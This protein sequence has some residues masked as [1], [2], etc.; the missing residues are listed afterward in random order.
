[1]FSPFGK[2]KQQA[3]PKRKAHNEMKRKLVYFIFGCAV[4]AVAPYVS[5]SVARLVSPL[6]G[7]G[8]YI[9][10]V[11]GQHVFIITVSEL[12][13][14]RFF[15]E[16]RRLTLQ[17]RL[18]VNNL[19]TPIPNF[20]PR[21]IK[22]LNYIILKMTFLCRKLEFDSFPMGTMTVT[23]KQQMLFPTSTPHNTSLRLSSDR[24]CSPTFDALVVCGLHNTSRSNHLHGHTKK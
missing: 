10:K 19:P 3:A 11:D 8:K 1:M 18:V 2:G 21:I 6:F 14:N 24:A 16:G 13:S 9:R 5:E 15:I 22:P 17:P 7:K 4:I 12:I 20:P 23:G